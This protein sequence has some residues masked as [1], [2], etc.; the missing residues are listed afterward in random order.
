MGGIEEIPDDS[1]PCPACG[2]IA[3]TKCTACKQVYYCKRDC[4]KKDW[5]THKPLCKAM[6]YK[7]ARN[8][9]LGNHILAN[10][11]IKEGEIILQESPLV[12]GPAQQTAPV[13][14]ACYVPV[15]GSYKCPRSGW[16]LCG[17]TCA[18][19]VQKNPEV[20]VP[21]Q[22]EA[23]F[24]VED[25]N[26]F[27]YLYECIIVLRA[28]LL[29]KQ[30]PS[31]YKALMSLESH[32]AERRDTEAWT[33]TQENV[34]DVMKKTL[35][36]MV[37]EALCPEFDFSD[38]TI[39]KI[40]G[41]LET[42]KK[43]IRLSQSDCEALYATACL[44]EHSCK[45]NVK[46]TFEK[47]FTIT[48]RAGRNI[49]EGE[50][51]STMYSHA[52]WGT[53]AR[54]DHLFQTKKFWCD[55][56]RCCDVTEFGSN[57]ST[58]YDEGHAMLPDN[59]LQSDADWVCEKTGIRRQAEEVKEQ[60]AKIGL[61]LEELAMKGNVDDSEN[62]LEK[63]KTLLHPNHYHMVACKHQLMQMYGRTE[64][65][66][67]QDMTEEQLKRKEDLC[68]EHIDVLKMIDPHCI[69]LMIFAAAAHF[70][71]HMPLLQVAKRKWEAGQ[72]STEDFR[73]ALK[74]P[75]THVK[76]AVA[77][78]QNETNE[79]LPEGQLRLQAVDTWLSWKD[80]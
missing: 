37:F 55:C 41:I 22:C 80:S 79:N 5:K 38:E 1:G 45:P 9:V 16:P 62:F 35:G 66:L 25:Y 32:V 68:R 64:G 42:N 7:I 46:I 17:P 59:P 13:C 26:K 39:Q 28:L 19:S 53:S 40:Q 60:L 72:L 54:R 18:R 15:D 67:I 2:K 21:A 57:L 58:I 11:D 14:L 4:Q 78:L 24:E 12:F 3:T 23:Q 74:D 20:L 61:E 33:R 50:H 48:V 51:I 31:K 65:Y 69:R 29:Q 77:L 76:T 73:S 43:E 49:A 71:L 30:S 27:S 47:D 8:S 44:L 56:E 36:I 10:R 52:M 63:Y 70:E 6:P 34:V 75:H